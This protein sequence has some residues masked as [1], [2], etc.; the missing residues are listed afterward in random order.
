V[1]STKTNKTVLEYFY[2]KL[3]ALGHLLRSRETGSLQLCRRRK[4]SEKGL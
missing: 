1:D 3:I 2:T 4:W